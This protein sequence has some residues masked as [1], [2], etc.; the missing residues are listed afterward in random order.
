MNCIIRIFCHRHVFRN[1]ISCL[2]YGWSRSL[3]PKVA[4]SRLGVPTWSSLRLD[5]SFVPLIFYHLISI[6]CSPSTFLFSSSTDHLL[7]FTIT[8]ISLDNT[9]YNVF[10]K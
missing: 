10:L 2:N 6:S 5:F 8:P 4:P 9:H 1:N 3:L 7:P